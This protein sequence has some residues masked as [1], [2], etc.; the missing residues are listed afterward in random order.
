MM[1]YDYR[2]KRERK[3]PYLLDM[4]IEYLQMKW[5]D[6]Y[7]GFALKQSKEGRVCVGVCIK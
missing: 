7:L 1:V 2:E 3:S 4:R 6:V 5:Y